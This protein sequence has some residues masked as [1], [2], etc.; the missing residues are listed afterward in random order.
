MWWTFSYVK[1]GVLLLCL[2][3]ER[4]VC[5]REGWLAVPTPTDALLALRNVGVAAGAL[6]FFCIIEMTKRHASDADLLELQ[7]YF[8]F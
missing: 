3:E 4:G 8:F 2:K 1:S 7:L 6:F 5:R